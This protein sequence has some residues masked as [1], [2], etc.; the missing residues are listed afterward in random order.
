MSGPNVMNKLPLTVIDSPIGASTPPADDPGLE[1]ARLHRRFD[2]MARLVGNAGIHHLRNSHAMVLG[3]GGVGSWAAEA[4]CRAGVG[5]ITL[6]DFDLVCVTNGNRQLHAVK[7]ATG[8]P[9][10]EV[11]ATRLKQINPSCEIIAIQ[12]FYEEA[13]SEALL[14]HKPDV[15]VDAIDNL[16]AKTHLISTC[17][18]QDIPLVV[19]GGASGRMDPTKIRE[20]DMTEISGDPFLAQTRKILRK[21][22]NFPAAD[23]G[24]WGI[25]TIH[26]LE[27]AAKP[28]ELEYDNGG[29]HQCVCPQGANSQHS[30]ERRSVIYGTAGFVTGAFGLACSAAAVRMLLDQAP[31]SPA[32]NP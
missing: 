3:M 30:C 5:K 17:R 26:S 31:V 6:V 15:L 29:G 16:T 22:F 11:M 13:T 7:G 18:I 14:A 1:R 8:K 9:K 2:R 4:L 20:A 10:V 32:E 12:K 28:L 23:L 19:C 21:T 24:P 27:P 25:A